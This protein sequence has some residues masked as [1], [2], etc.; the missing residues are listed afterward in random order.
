MK[1]KFVN[2]F[3]LGTMLLSMGVGFVA[4]MLKEKQWILDLKQ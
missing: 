1:K 3:L 4:L 2:A